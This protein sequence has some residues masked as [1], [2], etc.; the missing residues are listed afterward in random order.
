MSDDGYLHPGYAASLAEFGRPR[1]LPRA[2]GWILDRPIPGSSRRDATSAYPLFVCRDWAALAAD[3]EGLDGDL[4]SVVLVADPLADHDPA[5][6]SS[7]FDVVRSFKQHFVVDLGE[8]FG[9]TISSHHRRNARR[10]LAALEVERCAPDEDT[11]AEW[12]VLYRQLVARFS[13]DG[14][15]AFSAAAFAAQLRVPGLVAFRALRH[16][17]TVAMTLWYVGGTVG[18]YHLGASSERGY[19]LGA[20]FALFAT[21]FDAFANAGIRWIDL[22]GSAGSGDD[23][24]GGLARFKRGWASGTR[25]A[26]LLGKVLDRPAYNR[27][28]AGGAK[29]P[30]RLDRKLCLERASA[31]VEGPP[32][33]RAFSRNDGAHVP[34]RG[35]SANPRPS[36]AL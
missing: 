5:A 9:R 13:L 16:G 8:D 10:A 14:V 25:T 6:L 31:G 22:G 15:S 7:C 11:L 35:G 3:L 2:A 4:V 19:Q 28:A 12:I 23:P 20:S 27:L 34:D 1:L 24:G 26:W 36:L 29:R 18:Y 17:E 30:R 32:G 21:A 33:R